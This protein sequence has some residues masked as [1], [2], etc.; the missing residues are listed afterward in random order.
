MAEFVVAA[1]PTGRRLVAAVFTTVPAEL[2]APSTEIPKRLEVMR[3]HAG[4]VAF[5]LVPSAATV[6]V[7]KREVTLRGGAPASVEEPEEEAELAEAE[8]AMVAADDTSA[9][10]YSGLVKN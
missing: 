2:P 1:M 4:R 9:T 6:G 7:A 3:S 10:R 8:A 5:G